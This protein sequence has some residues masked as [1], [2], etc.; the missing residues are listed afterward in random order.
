MKKLILPAVFFG[1]FS[2][3]SAF[4]ACHEPVY[5]WPNDGSC[6]FDVFCLLGRS[7]D[8]DVRDGVKFQQ[9]HLDRI[10]DVDQSPP[11]PP[12]CAKPQKGSRTLGPTMCY[13]TTDV[14]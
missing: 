9:C 2:A 4:A 8:M 10:N 6:V 12:M 5:P 14:N 1:V 7:G 13:P 11:P 3:T